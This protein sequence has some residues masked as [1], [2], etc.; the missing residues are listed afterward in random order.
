MMPVPAS[1]NDLTADADLQK[2]VGWVWYQTNYIIPKRYLLSNFEET[3][4]FIH[5]GSVNYAAFVVRILIYFF[6]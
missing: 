3:R 2:H 5:F 1:Y 6:K 4:S